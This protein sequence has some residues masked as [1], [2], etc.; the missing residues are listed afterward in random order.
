MKGGGRKQGLGG[1]IG[2]SHLR[3]LY[4]LHQK[5]VEAT[6]N[7]ESIC[8]ASGAGITAASVLGSSGRE[9]V[10]GGAPPAKA[11]KKSEDVA[12]YASFVLNRSLWPSAWEEAL[13]LL[14]VA[15]P[16]FFL[17]DPREARHTANVWFFFGRNPLTEGDGKGV[18]QGRPEH[19][20][21]VANSGTWHAQQSGSKLWFIR[22]DPA[23]RWPEG[24]RCP[25]CRPQALTVKAD[26]GDLLVI[27]TDL[28]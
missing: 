4:R 1:S 25:E 3:Q 23:A 18:L 12:W 11:P 17:K 20:D 15:E 5:A 26:A 13:G 9:E 22:P 16:H 8:S 27:N 2:L 6:W 28:W 7:L 21:K 24:S 19:T 10:A 14:P